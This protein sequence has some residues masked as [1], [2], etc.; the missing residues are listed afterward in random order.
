M[1]FDNG[2]EINLRNY[3]YNFLGRM[4]CG[5]NESFLKPLLGLPFCNECTFVHPGLSVRASN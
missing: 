2:I 4:L 1:D 5:L 3:F